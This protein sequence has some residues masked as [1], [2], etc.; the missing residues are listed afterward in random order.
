MKNETK[1]Q[2]AENVADAYI[3]IYDKLDKSN[4][5]AEYGKS[6]PVQREHQIAKQANEL[7]TAAHLGI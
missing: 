7:F 3:A 2:K 1:K 4:F 6:H 5:Y